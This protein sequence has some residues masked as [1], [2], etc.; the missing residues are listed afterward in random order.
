[1][2]PSHLSERNIESCPSN[3]IKYKD[4][5]FCG[6]LSTI[7]AVPQFADQLSCLP[8]HKSCKLAGRSCQLQTFITN[9]QLL[10]VYV[11]LSVFAETTLIDKNN[12]NTRKRIVS[13]RS[14]L[15][16]VIARQCLLAPFVP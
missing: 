6:W 15:C 14:V 4:F 9:I 10:S 11:Q 3:D 1:M 12:A 2:A 16:A 13:K 7:P 8:C 5:F